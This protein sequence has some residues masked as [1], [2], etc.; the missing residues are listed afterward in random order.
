MS[1]L[2]PALALHKTLR[3]ASP[4]HG[5][6]LQ[7]G[8]AC[9]Y[10]LARESKA[11]HNPVAAGGTV[12]PDHGKRADGVSEGQPEITPELLLHA[13]SIGVFPM[14]ESRDDPHIF[15]LDPQFRGIL[16][17]DTFHV[18]KRL[19][20]TVRAGVFDVRINTA[21]REVMKGCA[22]SGPGREDT[23]INEQILDL[24]CALHDGGCAHSVECWQ[25]GAL[26]GGLY[27]V[28][29]GAA[30]FGESMFTRV[31]DASKVALVH[32]VAR[33][34]AGGYTLLDTQFVSEHLTKFGAIELPRAIY[35]ARLRDA[36]VRHAD[37]YRLEESPSGDRVLQL[38][39]QT[40]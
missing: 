20:R 27:G 35:H 19:K 26:V 17:L 3:Q 9:H 15:F 29:L 32:L 14:A 6:A 40:S 10:P 18:P 1:N 38:I 24:Y 4:P 34:I 21:F 13:Y 28:E 2:D 8:Q 5:H 36:V 30:F 23:W 16:P 12:P 7:I 31:T 39:T 22:D 37:F 33:M 11:G 25:D